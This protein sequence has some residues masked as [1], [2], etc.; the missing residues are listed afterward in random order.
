MTRRGLLRLMGIAAAAVIAAPLLV[1]LGRALRRR[2]LTKDDL[3]D[4]PWIGHC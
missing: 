1:K 3:A 2:P 4:V